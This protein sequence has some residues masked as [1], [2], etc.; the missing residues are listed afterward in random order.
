MTRSRAYW[1]GRAAKRMYGYMD[2]AELVARDIAK[3]YEQSMA[4]LVGETE[5]VMRSFQRLTGV[6]EAEA[7]RLLRGA[8]GKKAI[9]QINSMAENVADPKARQQLHDNIAAYG[10]RA[11]RLDDLAKDIDAKCE[12]IYKAEN[13]ASTKHYTKL[14]D[15]AYLHSVYDLQVGT[16]L[17]FSFS[18]MPKSKIDEMLRN[19]WSGEHYSTRI[20]G[21]TQQL[22]EVLK[23]ELLTGF[24]TGRA[25]DKTALNIA[26]KMGAGASEARRLVRTDSCY[27]ANRAEQESYRECG[28]DTYIYV[29]TLDRRTS[30]ICRKLDGK[31]FPVAEGE[32]GKNMPPMH[33]WCR[34]TTIAGITDEVLAGLKRSARDP[35]TG[36]TY[37][38]PANMT[39][40][41]WGQYVQEN[42]RLLSDTGKK[43]TRKVK[44]VIA[45]EKVGGYTDLPAKY[46]EAF[47][48]GLS[49]AEPIA[50]NVLKNEVKETDFYL[51]KK[52]RSLYMPLIN[53]VEINPESAPSTL[54]HEMFHKLDFKYNVTKN[55]S[56]DLLLRSD[57]GDLIKRAGNDVVSYLNEVYPEAFALSKRGTL[58]MRPEYRGISDIFSGL[59]ENQLKLGYG[60]S[61]KYWRGA[62]NRL[63]MEAWAQFGRVLYENDPN[64]KKMFLGLFPGFEKGAMIALKELK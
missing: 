1:E 10:A 20:W 36:Q 35:E 14:A 22:A 64:V 48:R 17:G 44:S 7:K 63:E 30:K 9:D 18:M 24:M 27:I 21:N 37:T 3:A 23:E 60:H 56:F 59:T 6:S 42:N 19:P 32:P 40:E 4:Y 57:Y 55:S 29:A 26:Q 33:P 25:Y 53:A 49:R 28:I 54:A 31:R 45:G 11:K 2:D 43:L 51:S 61:V 8:K 62:K 46:R 34:S 12:E 50:G 16:G 52:E 39:Y 58:R 5:K 41:Q 38:V 13:M 47:E 15:E